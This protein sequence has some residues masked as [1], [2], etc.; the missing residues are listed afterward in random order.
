MRIAVTGSTGMVG[1]EVIRY[2]KKQGHAVTRILRTDSH[3]SPNGSTIHWDIVSRKIDKNGLENHD[4]VIHLAGA[5][6]AGKRWTEQYKEQIRASR[7]DGTRLLCKALAE[8]KNPPKVLL[9]ASA[10]GYY[11]SREPEQSMDESKLIGEGFLPE[12]CDQWEKATRPAELA[13]IR[14]VHMRIGTVI[15]TKGGALAKMLPPFKMGLGGRL[16]SGRQMFSWIALE[17]LPLVMDHLIKNSKLSGPINVTS[18]KPVSNAEFT[19]ILG[20]Q[21]KRPIFFPVPA[22]GVKVL[23]GEMGDRLLLEGAQVV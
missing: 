23:F 18:P 12:V 19:R 16:G 22:F 9:S 14:V 6:I 3:F 17:E 15:S 4:V 2:F 8:L 13:G 11:G 1:N 5:N 20:E 7:V 10:I 21:L